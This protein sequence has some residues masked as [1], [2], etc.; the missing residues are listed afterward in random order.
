MNFTPEQIQHELENIQSMEGFLKE[1]QC[2]LESLQSTQPHSDRVNSEGTLFPT[3]TY[4]LASGDPHQ[5]QFTSSSSRRA[6]VSMTPR[7]QSNVGFASAPIRRDNNM[8]RSRSNMSAQSQPMSRSVSQASLNM[9]SQGFFGAGMVD[10]VYQDESPSPQL[11]G[12]QV[13]P[14]ADRLPKVQEDPTLDVGQTPFEYLMSIEPELRMGGL[15]NTY[16]PAI[17]QNDYVGY[18]DSNGTSATPSLVSADSA[19]VPDMGPLTRENSSIGHAFIDALPPLSRTASHGPAELTIDL[20]GAAGK[21]A[22]MS[23]HFGMGS[24]TSEKMSLNLRATKEVSPS[25]CLAPE[26]TEMLRTTS[27]SSMKSTASYQGRR[28][29]E[30]LERQIQNGSRIAIA[31]REGSEDVKSTSKRA[32]STGSSPSKCSASAKRHSTIAHQYQRRKQPKVFCDKCNEY[33]DGF[34]GEHELRRHTNS[35]HAKLVAKWVCRDPTSVGRKP[36]IDAMYPLS[37]CK[38]CLSTKKYGAYYN[39]AAHLRRAHFRKR[40]A[41][42]K[43]RAENRDNRKAKQQDSSWPPMADLKHW[44]VRVL[45]RK[46]GG[47]EIIQEMEEDDGASFDAE[48]PEPSQQEDSSKPQEHD[49]DFVTSGN[50]GAFD[51]SALD[52]N[53]YAGMM[54]DLDPLDTIMDNYDGSPN[55][56]TVGSSCAGFDLSPYQNSASSSPYEDA[57]STMASPSVGSGPYDVFQPTTH[58]F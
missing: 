35:K 17:T 6:T 23:Y 4:Q 40:T 27:G 13:R 57:I 36:G 26:S 9:G 34:R 33:P 29:K 46:D 3:N 7:S 44:M 19:T 41:R 16:Y 24:S 1:R 39:A 58:R 28:A 48:C 14:V 37:K 45:V 54:R 43:K 32:D 53:A 42:G 5:N 31:P 15:M 21:A 25:L 8:M 38:A 49:I 18:S 12:S 55:P 56:A 52:V 2:F 10:G 51:F 47:E 30:A 22:A 50:G 20:G 11:L